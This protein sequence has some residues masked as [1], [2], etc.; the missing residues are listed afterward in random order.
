MI[1]QIF[2][3]IWNTKRKNTLLFIEIL[4][5]FL[6]LFG[7]YTFLFTGYSIYS[8]S[9]GFDI[10][11][12][13]TVSLPFTE[14]MDSIAKVQVKQQVRNELL[15][16]ADVI[17]ASFSNY[18]IPYHSGGWSSDTYVDGKEAHSFFLVADDKYAGVHGL[19]LIRGRW[20]EEGDATRRIPPIVINKLYVDRYLDNRE[21][22]GTIIQVDGADREVVGVISHYK[23]RSDFLSESPMT[24]MYEPSLTDRS[25]Y[26]NIRV[27]PGTPA[28]FE[29]ELSNVLEGTGLLTGFQILK[30]ES[31]RPVANR[32]FMIPM[33][34][35][36]FL[37]TFLILNVALGLFGVVWY[38]INNRTSE[39]GL[40]R[41]V[42][43]TKQMIYFQLAGEQLAIAT[44]SIV[45]GLII[46]VQFPI[47]KV[48]YLDASLYIK[49][50][51]LAIVTV[52][53]VILICTLLPGRKASKIHPAI[54]LHEE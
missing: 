23:Y 34:I 30:T 52:L 29:F 22:L 2:H 24:V 50:M 28:T 53:V 15:N 17:D 7:V 25:A 33:Y 37:C 41:A 8:V 45:I 16:N 40:R 13:F 14:G 48:F 12:T 20:F 43:A 51:I 4:I 49:G 10:D 21:P 38:N 44:I 3:L 42:G 6:V 1:K 9:S 46:A 31:Q 39:I 11:D 27:K 35:F 32:F 5:S 54:A 18:A 47:L 26:L 36:V 19:E